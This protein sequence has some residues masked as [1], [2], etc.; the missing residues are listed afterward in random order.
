MRKRSKYKPKQASPSRWLFCIRDQKPFEPHEQTN[1][2]LMGW[3]AYHSLCRGDGDPDDIAAMWS[4]SSVLKYRA[5]TIGSEVV[6]IATKGIAAAK[7]A[8]DRL[9]KTGKVGLDGEAIQALKDCLEVFD[10]LLKLS[11]A[12]DLMKALDKV[13]KERERYATNTVEA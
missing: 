11:S 4:M 6:E 7:R 12:G 2:S 5:E 9:Q 8:D 10:D 1:I 3:Q 13:Q